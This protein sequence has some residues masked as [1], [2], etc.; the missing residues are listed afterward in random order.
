[1]NRLKSGG[2]QAGGAFDGIDKHSFE[3]LGRCDKC[4]E[5][6]KDRYFTG[7]CPECNNILENGKYIINPNFFLNLDDRAK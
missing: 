2:F 3:K 5:L 4:L 6:R 7:Y 1:M